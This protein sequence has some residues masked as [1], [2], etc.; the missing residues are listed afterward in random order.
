MLS[1]SVTVRRISC[2]KRRPTTNS[3]NHRPAI[4]RSFLSGLPPP[5]RLT[6]VAHQTTLFALPV[7]IGLGLAL[8]VGLLARRQRHLEFHQ[9]LVVEIEPGRHQRAAF[10]L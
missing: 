1:M 5:S 10:A 9:A 8:V 4:E 2:T 6:L 7:A 3:S